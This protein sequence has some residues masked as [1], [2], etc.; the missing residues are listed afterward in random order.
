METHLVLNTPLKIKVFKLIKHVH[1]NAFIITLD[2][3]GFPTLIK[4]KNGLLSGSLLTNFLGSVISVINLQAFYF[5][6]AK[7]VE[8]NEVLL[9]ESMMIKGDDS[10]HRCTENFSIIEFSKFVKEFSSMD[11]KID[12]PDGYYTKKDQPFHFLGALIDS[13]GRY[14]DLEL[15]RR[16]LCVSEH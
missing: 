11:I 12:S 6:N 16:Q 3:D 4:K 15:M 14:P 2:K 13:K 10:N 7:L 9:T 1:L 8:N 5:Y